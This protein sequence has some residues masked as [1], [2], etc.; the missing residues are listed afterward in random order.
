M[1]DLPHSVRRESLRITTASEAVALSLR[2][3]VL[4]LNRTALLPIIERVLDECGTTDMYVRIDRL[5]VDL[6]SMTAGDLE[7]LLPQRFEREL[8]ERLRHALGRVD[9]NR[10]AT[11]R[12][13]DAARLEAVEQYL[14]TGTIPFWASHRPF[15]LEDELDVLLRADPGAIAR[16]FRRRGSADRL[17]RRAVFRLGENTLRRLLHVL[18][19]GDAALIIVYLS[20]VRDY[21]AVESLIPASDDIVSRTLWVVALTY[22]LRDPGTQFN[23]TS[24]LRALLEGLAR[25]E[26]WSYQ[27]MLYVFDMAVRQMGRRLPIGTTLLASVQVLI[28]QERQ[29]NPGFGA[30]E[31]ASRQDDRWEASTADL[32]TPVERSLSHYEYTDALRSYLRNGTFPWA[33]LVRKPDLTIEEAVTRL[34]DLTLPMLQALAQDLASEE[35]VRGWLLMTR[36]MSEETLRRLLDVLLPPAPGMERTTRAVLEARAGSQPDRR[37]FYATEIVTLLY[38]HQRRPHGGGWGSHHVAEALPSERE[39]HDTSWMASVLT[40]RAKAAIAASARE[41]S[42]TALL[43]ALAR[44]DGGGAR[45]WLT[46]I[47]DAG[48]RASALVDESPTGAGLRVIAGALLPPG[49]T[50]AFT[51]LLDALDAMPAADLP[52]AADDVRRVLLRAILDHRQSRTSGS[53]MPRI[54]LQLFGRPLPRRVFDFMAA[55]A[56]RL[57]ASGRITASALESV[58]TMLN[59]LEPLDARAVT[60]APQHDGGAG[61]S[62]DDDQAAAV[63]A[64]LGEPGTESVPPS[65]TPLAQDAQRHALHQAMDR[66]PGRVRSMLL[67]RL[68]DPRA[69]WRWVSAL[70]ESELARVAGLIEPRHS[71]A[72]LEAA[73]L[74][75]AAWAFAAPDR[76]SRLVR[77]R[78]FWGLVLAFLASTGGAD[79]TVGRLVAFF[80]AHL[81]QPIFGSAT[82][83]T[84][85]SSLRERLRQEAVRLADNAGNAALRTVLSHDPEPHAGPAIAAARGTSGASA[86]PQAPQAP[87]VSRPIQPPRTDGRR[88]A[89]SMDESDPG[90]EGEPIYISNAGLVLTTPFL[91]RLFQSL[92]MLESTGTGSSRIRLPQI[93]RAVHLLQWMVD[94]RTSAPEPLLCLNKLLCGVPTATPV[95]PGIEPTPREI[96]TGTALLRSILTNWP[97]VSNTSIAGLQETFLQREGRLERVAHGWKL[98]V[99]RRTVDVLVDHLPWS[100]STV[101]HSLMPAPIF[102]SW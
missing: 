16:L 88:M 66:A 75:F 20:E 49:D 68:A 50:D 58:S 38:G 99:Q 36:A 12:S 13:A 89:F 76:S 28:E 35:Q 90:V 91:P 6:G 4:E 74:L 57:A 97:I 29:S 63:L 5:D 64:W 2:T 48:V 8:R 39:G 22:V 26:Q 73:E 27:D 11:V 15:D 40:T 10:R 37:L 98:Q 17:V 33:L 3:T 93:S 7:R 30:G 84:E 102:V 54:L 67:D 59:P 100:V 1:A 9:A 60:P 45:R 56:D 43:L 44:A 101:V 95:E 18:A 79:R 46:A 24:L 47:G 72:L 53:L 96:E 62:T 70:G 25:A 83:L 61:R 21:H 77:R 34:P 41:P 92:D 32:L 42:S 65:A 82:P 80:F 69:R 19:P 52:G 94:G 85:D 81:S 31:A 78:A 87:A 71:A 51:V 14:L 86:T 55:T 23:R